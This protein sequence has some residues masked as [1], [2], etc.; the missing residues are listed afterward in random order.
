M[1]RRNGPRRSTLAGGRLLVGSGHDATSQ[2]PAQRGA[3]GVAG[4]GD[5]DPAGTPKRLLFVDV[6]DNPRGDAQGGEVA[7]RCPGRRPVRSGIGTP[8]VRCPG[9][10]LP[11]RCG[12]RAGVGWDREFIS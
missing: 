1:N 2:D 9:G 4:A 3:Q 6:D 12:G 8:P 10:G 5:L 11:L 7:Q